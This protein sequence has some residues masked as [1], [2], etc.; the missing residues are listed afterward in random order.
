[1]QR[2]VL[3]FLAL[4]LSVTGQGQAPTWA[5]D[6]ACIAFSH[7]TSCHHPGGISGDAVDMTSYT[8]AYGHRD[9]IRDYTA[10]RAM[11]PWPPDPGYRSHAHERLLTQEEIDIITAWVNADAP[12]G[13]AANAPPTPVYTTEWSI[14]SPDLTVKMPDYTVPTLTTDLYQAFVIHV[15]NTTD[16][17][18]KQFEVIPGNNAAVH[19]VLVYQDTTGEAQA[20]DD[21]Q[22]GPGYVSFGGIGVADAKLIGLWVP[23]SGSFTAPQGMAIK[24]YAGADIV[25]QV[26]YPETSEGLLDSTRVNFQYDPSTFV[27]ELGI[28][29][30]L[31]H[32]ITMTDGPLVIPPNSIQT[33]HNH[34]QLAFPTT[35]VGIGPHAHLLCKHMRSYAV[36]PAQDT[37]PFVDLQWDFHWQ[38]MYE[39]RHP[40]YLPTGTWLYGEAT[41]DNT[42]ANEDNPNHLNPQ[43]VTLGESTTDE[44]MLFFFAYTYGF[45]SDENM[46]IDDSPHQTHYLGCSTDF[47][48]GMPETTAGEAVRITPVPAHDVITVHSDRTGARSLL[49]DTQ[50][51][52]LLRSDL[53]QGDN[54]INVIDLPRGVLIAEV[55]DGQGRVL[56]RSPLLLQ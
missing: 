2:S 34:Y 14:P 21:A 51:R 20:L 9:D 41:Y 50:G 37:I 48:I 45:P 30:P 53:L 5:D 47:N 29:A 17:W 31:E 55:R 36:T 19:H 15:G 54:S 23:G 35:V 27:R 25:I 28:T 13:I 42:A 1:M 4:L 46:V 38:G 40:I 49:F 56:H 7:C 32:T 6:V 26:H 18:I 43:W 11:P 16:K 24:L 10:A 33:F 44:M 22:P 8:D 39:F 52:E 12:E 3:P